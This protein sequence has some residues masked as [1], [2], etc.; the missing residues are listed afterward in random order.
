VIEPAKSRWRNPA[1]L[2]AGSPQDLAEQ[3]LD[4]RSKKLNPAIAQD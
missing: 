3:G 1:A 4:R 2:P